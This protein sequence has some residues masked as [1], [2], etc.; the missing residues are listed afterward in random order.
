MLQ[1]PCFAR[2]R[3]PHITYYNLTSKPMNYNGTHSNYIIQYIHSYPLCCQIRRVTAYLQR[4]KRF[5]ISGTA[6]AVGVG[7]LTRQRALPEFFFFCATTR[8]I[9]GPLGGPNIIGPTVH[10]FSH[11]LHPPTVPTRLSVTNMSRARIGIPRWVW[12]A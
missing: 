2:Q 12:S 11:F 7:P 1:Q 8:N 10:P 9:S 4:R 6:S 3:Q 5:V